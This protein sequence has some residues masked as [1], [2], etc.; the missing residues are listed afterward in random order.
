MLNFVPNRDRRDVV[1]HGT[2][3]TAVTCR[4]ESM[5]SRCTSVAYVELQSMSLQRKLAKH[6]FGNRACTV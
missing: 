1:M 5:S 2:R 6:A 3:G 4:I